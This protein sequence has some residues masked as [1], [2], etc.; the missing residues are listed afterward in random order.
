MPG[1]PLRHPRPLTAAELYLE[2]EKEQEAV[3]NRLTRELTALRAQSASVASNASS[4]SSTS[5]NA[6]LLPVDI[7]DPNP[8]HQIMGATH[9]TPSR[10]HRSSSSVSASSRGIPTPSTSASTHAHPGSIS[11]ASADRAAAAGGERNSLSRNP[12]VNASGNNTPAR[13]SMEISRSA[14]YALPH[15]PSLSRDPSQTTISSTHAQAGSPAPSHHIV[16][17]PL[18]SPA[19]S[20]ASQVSVSN[21]MQHFADTRAQREELEH[22]KRENDALRQRVRDLE[23]AL[24]QRR[25]DS[26]QSVDAQRPADLTPSN[27][28]E[29]ASREFTRVPSFTSPPHSAGLGVWDGGVGGVAGPRERSESQSTTASSRRGVGIPEDD[30]IRVGESANSVGVGVGLG[31]GA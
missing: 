11:Q 28:L 29:R 24:R 30:S 6:S 4:V 7:T 9:P 12:S 5:A 14:Q 19:Q 26:S 17:N 18:P 23:R 20:P 31:R 16:P 21:A 27:T 13:R 3:V 25:R 1:L 10:R 15:R 8:T 2:C 22:V